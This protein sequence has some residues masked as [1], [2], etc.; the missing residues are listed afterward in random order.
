[1]ASYSESWVKCT[2]AHGARS[3]GCC[4]TACLSALIHTDSECHQTRSPVGDWSPRTGRLSATPHACL[5]KRRKRLFPAPTTCLAA[6]TRE[7][8]VREP[9]G[10]PLERPETVGR[11]PTRQDLESSV[12]L[13]V[14]AKPDKLLPL[15]RAAAQ[16][17]IHAAHAPRA[18]HIDRLQRKNRRLRPRTATTPGWPAAPSSQ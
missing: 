13:S 15:A 5:G 8:P 12:C 16:R 7:T 14:S 11:C 17:T 10:A 9:S 1:M 2:A 3:S 6:R 18:T 4:K